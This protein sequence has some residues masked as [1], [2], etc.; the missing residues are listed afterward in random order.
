[1]KSLLSIRHLF[2]LNSSRII[3]A[4]FDLTLTYGEEVRNAEVIALAS[5]T[6]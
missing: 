6:T 1:M 3:D 2:K 5:S 4:N